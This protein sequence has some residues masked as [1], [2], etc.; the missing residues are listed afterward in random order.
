MLSVVSKVLS[1]ITISRMRDGVEAKLREERAAYVRGRGTTEHIF[2]VRNIIEQSLEWRT[3][4]YVHFVDFEKS[5]D[6]IHRESWWTIM[7][8]Y[9]ITPPTHT[10]IDRKHCESFL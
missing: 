5:F 7:K 10:H 6:S 4:L 3:S 1:G 9:R 2:V 8:S